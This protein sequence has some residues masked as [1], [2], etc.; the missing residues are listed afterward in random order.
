MKKKYTASIKD[1]KDWEDFIGQI[2]DIRPKEEDEIYNNVKSDEIKKLDLHGFSLNE[3][4]QK[5]EEFLIDSFNQGCRKILII[6]GKG[7]RSKINENPY[8]SREFGVLK[9][10]IPEFIK[11]DKN[12]NEKIIKIVTADNKHGGNGAIYVF[13]KKNKI[14]K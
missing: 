8:I 12:L 6:T 2:E 7:S 10:S 13:L 9:N 11:N 5:L 1:K 14:T 4:N 3:A